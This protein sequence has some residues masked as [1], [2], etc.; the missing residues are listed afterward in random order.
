MRNTRVFGPKIATSCTFRK[1]LARIKPTS[2]RTSCQIVS[3][4][5]DVNAREGLSATLE[6]SFFF[7]FARGRDCAE[8]ELPTAWEGT[9][10]VRGG[11]LA[12]SPDTHCASCD[13]E[14]KS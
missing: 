8:L 13:T 5:S 10:L 4:F 2:A 7:S 1:A 12:P 11:V 3:R 9:P 6:V 14:T